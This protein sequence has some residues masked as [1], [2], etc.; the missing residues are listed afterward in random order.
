MELVGRRLGMTNFLLYL[1]GIKTWLIAG[2]FGATLLT[3]GTLYGVKQYKDWQQM[4]RTRESAIKF[5]QCTA[6]AKNNSDYQ[7]CFNRN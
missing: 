7:Q 4:K 2:A 5:A 3:A 1:S 6:K